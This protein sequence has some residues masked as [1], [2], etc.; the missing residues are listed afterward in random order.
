M[1][2]QANPKITPAHLARKAIVYVR[3]SS[4]RQVQRNHESRRLQYA[5]RERAVALGWR[6]VDVLDEDLGRSAGPGSLRTGFEKMIAAVAM[7]EVGVIF[8][9]EASRLSRTDK[10]WCRLVELCAVFGTLIADSENVYDIRLPDDQLLVG[11]KGT[12]SVMELNLLKARM[13][14]GAQAKAARGEL[15][16]ILPAG[17]VYDG[18]GKV[19]VDPDRRVREA[20]A[21]V[22]RKYEQFPSVRQLY[23]WF[24]EESIEL[25]AKR[26]SSGRQ[27]IEWSLPG[28]NLIRD[29]LRNPVFA[30]AYAFGRRQT[31]VRCKDNVLVKREGAFLPPQQWKVLIRDHHEGYITWEQYEQNVKKMRS[32]ALQLGA[33]ADVAAVRDGQGLLN[34]L[35]RC[36]RCGHKLHVRYWGKAGTAARYLCKGDFEDGGGYCLGFGGAMVDRRFSRELLEV[37]EPMTLAASLRALEA[38]DSTRDQ[39]MHLLG[40]QLEEARYAAERAF[41]QY[42]AVDARNRLAAGELEKRWNDK[43]QIV[44][45]LSRR[46]SDE[47]ADHAQLTEGEKKEIISLAERFAAVWEDPRCPPSLKK[48]LIRTIVKEIIVNQEGPPGQETL[49][50]VIHWKG[51][52]HTEIRMPKPQSSVT[53]K[54]VTEDLDLI[55]AMAKRHAD[56]QIARVLNKLG[57][58][59]AK[60]NRWRADR[61]KT[62]RHRHGIAAPA[63]RAED[64]EI[65]GIVPAAK[66]RGVSATTIRRLAARGILHYQQVAPYAPW[67]ISKRD[68]DTDPVRSICEHLKRTGKLDLDEGCCS[69]QTSLFR[70]IPDELQ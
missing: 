6:E 70:E 40:T 2:A 36:G 5:L 47:R 51:G 8:S 41:E 26:L 10:D 22:F 7:A 64:D 32:S 53:K 63:R 42:N 29:T 33:E 48:E 11:I 16:K 43:L 69:G 39:T 20:V 18:M 3:Q 45:Q 4:E 54:T 66:Y 31:E 25:P 65:I 46:I 62:T 13:I 37:I 14:R 59:T 67:V 27:V 23:L 19:A 34:P 52:V 58:T 38:C 15:R 9:L 12:L 50:F 17:Y 35:L 24:R 1:T 30:G 44:E 49:C 28:I 60:G 21:L 55:R 57:R 61:V 68:L 56:A